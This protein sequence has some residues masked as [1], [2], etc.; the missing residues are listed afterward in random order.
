VRW[1]SNAQLTLTSQTDPNLVGEITEVLSAERV[2]A[3]TKGGIER[4]QRART[5]GALDGGVQVTAS[6]DVP[7]QSRHDGY[8]VYCGRLN[9]SSWSNHQAASADIAPPGAPAPQVE[10]SPEVQ[11]PTEQ[12]E[13]SWSDWAKEITGL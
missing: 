6:K 10:Q 12:A 4:S 11:E 7:A 9:S 5:D 8:F 1:V 2:E 3:N 13:Q